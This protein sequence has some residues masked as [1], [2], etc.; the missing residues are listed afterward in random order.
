MEKYFDEKNSCYRD[1]N[2]RR[3]CTI[4]N[5]TLN[6]ILDNCKEELNLRDTIDLWNVTWLLQKALEGNINKKDLTPSEQN[7]IKRIRSY[8]KFL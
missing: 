2:G 6:K 4:E 3:L 5:D 1:N 7:A 8:I